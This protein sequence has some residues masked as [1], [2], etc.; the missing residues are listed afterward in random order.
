MLDL[1]LPNRIINPNS[2]NQKMDFDKSL[3]KKDLS[4]IKKSI[5][6]KALEALKSESKTQNN[7]LE[8]HISF[9]DKKNSKKKH[10]R[11]KMI[12]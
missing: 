9:K 4:Q 5:I 12:S 11:R 10:N 1:H 6:S 7:E 2:L 3:E 8:N